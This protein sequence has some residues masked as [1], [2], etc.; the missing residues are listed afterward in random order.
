MR[1]TDLTLSLLLAVALMPAGALAGDVFASAPGDVAVT[2]YRNPVRNV[3]AALDLD[4]LGGFAL[5]TEVRTVKVPAGESRIR[6]EGVAN[7]IEAASALVTGLPTGVLEKDRDGTILSP[8]SLVAMTVG[9]HLT[10]VRTDT[11]SGKVSKVSGRL[12]SVEDGVVFQSDQGEIEALRCSGLPETLEFDPVTD[13]HPAPTLSA[14][15]RTPKPF[16]ATVKLTYLSFGFDWTASYSFVLAPDGNSMELGGWVTLANNNA[17]SFQAARAQVVAGRLD[18]ED[19]AVQPISADRMVA[20][21]WPVGTTSDKAARPRI[22]RAE[23]LW[24][25][26]SGYRLEEYQPNGNEVVVT[27]SRRQQA[28]I[29]DAPLAAPAVAEL[30]NEEALGD[31]KL[32]RVPERTTVSSFQQKQVRLVDRQAIPLDHY[33]GA[34]IEANSTV[35]STTLRHF[36]RARNDAQHHLGLP[37]PAGGVDLLTRHDGVPLLM[38]GGSIGDTAIDQDITIRLGYAADVRLSQDGSRIDLTNAE[39]YPVKVEV[40][41]QIPADEKVIEADHTPF[42]HRGRTSFHVT[43]P[44]QGSLSIHYQTGPGNLKTHFKLTHL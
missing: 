21:C 34:D 11:A 22:E 28:A 40:G 30:V 16:S 37:L 39:N 10:L 33:Y 14:W 20:N 24:E 36:L 42:I 31:L 17:V 27:G 1:P 7:G 18:R 32:Y 19:D 43:V 44:A 25:G 9:H 8:A 23:P 41:L 6:F 3:T 5:V 15:V 13:L 12:Q 26:P 2:V 4:Q 38:G 35:D 29:L